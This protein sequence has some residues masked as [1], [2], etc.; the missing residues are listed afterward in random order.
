M[1]NS[2]KILELKKKL[3]EEIQKESSD[4]NLILSLSNEIAKLDENQVRFSVDAGLINR[5]G[6]ELVGKHETAV[7]ELVKNA[8]DADA[9]EVKLV[10]ENAGKKGGTVTIEDNGTG[11]TKDQ[12][13]NG[14]MRLSSSDKIHNP[15]SEK[16][17][18]T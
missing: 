1:D 18:R 10:F 9:T 17:K 6:K 16:Y 2:T 14:F 7:S 13:I 5:L 15:I 4:N 11:M 8:F 3:S 12:L